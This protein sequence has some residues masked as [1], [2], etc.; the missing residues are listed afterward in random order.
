MFI[1]AIQVAKFP[2]DGAHLLCEDGVRVESDKNIGQVGFLVHCD[3]VDALAQHCYRQAEHRHHE[4]AV[5]A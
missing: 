1:I 2:V 4:V 5:S 3:S